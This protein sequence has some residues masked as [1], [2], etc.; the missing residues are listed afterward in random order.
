IN[1]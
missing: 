1:K